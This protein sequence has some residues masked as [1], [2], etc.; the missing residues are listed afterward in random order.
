MKFQKGIHEFQEKVFDIVVVITYLL[1]FLIAFDLSETAPVYLKQLDNFIKVYISLFLIYRFNPFRETKF[2]DLDR[3][4]VFSAG[5]FVL[6][7]TT[8]NTLLFKYFN[9]VV[10]EVNEKKNI[11][12][13]K[14]A[15]YTNIT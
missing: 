1:Y 9:K 14:N 12:N 2:T 10:D 8:I 7:T 5:V 3:K 11:K 4:I 15:Y 6:A 13:I